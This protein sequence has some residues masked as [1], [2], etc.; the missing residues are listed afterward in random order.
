MCIY[1]IRISSC[2]YRN[3][4]KIP[5]LPSKSQFKNFKKKILMVYYY[6]S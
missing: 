6:Q 4:K 3:E 5:I 2:S 1:T